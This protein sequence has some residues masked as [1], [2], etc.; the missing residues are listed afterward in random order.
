VIAN[1]SIQSIS[2]FQWGLVPFWTK[3]EVAAD[4]IRTNT[5]NARAE[6]IHKKP[7][8]AG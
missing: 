1:E 7:V 4:R 2:F 8:A 5:L 3:D 6:T